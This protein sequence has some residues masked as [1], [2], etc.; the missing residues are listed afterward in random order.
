ML[1][2]KLVFGLAAMVMVL[3]LAQSSYAQLNISLIGNPAPRE[4]N[5]NRTGETNDPETG[6]GIIISGSFRL[7]SLSLVA[8]YALTGLERSR[9]VRHFLARIP[10]RLQQQM[11]FSPVSPTPNSAWIMRR[12]EFTSPCLA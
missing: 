1:K 11:E 2:S 3:A 8:V 12:D 10:S 9:T 5:T 4:T 6:N 7:Q